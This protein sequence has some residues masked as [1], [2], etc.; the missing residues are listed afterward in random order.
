MT[1]MRTKLKDL[2]DHVTLYSRLMV[3]DIQGGFEEKWILLK[4]SWACVCPLPARPYKEPLFNVV[5]RHEGRLPA[6]FKII[7]KGQELVTVTPGH[8]DAQQRWVSVIAQGKK[9][10]EHQ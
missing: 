9:G 6:W 3:P 4:K 8:I 10:G 2:R 5:L 1:M 7:W